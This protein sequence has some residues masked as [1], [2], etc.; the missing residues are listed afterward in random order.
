MSEILDQYAK[1]LGK[2]VSAMFSPN[3]TAEILKITPDLVRSWLRKNIIKGVKI[4][5]SWMV[6]KSEIERILQSNPKYESW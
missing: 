6:P 1:S 2:D 3:E 5:G 4:S